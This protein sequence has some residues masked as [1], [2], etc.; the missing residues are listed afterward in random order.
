MK[1]LFLSI[2]TISTVLVSCKNKE[3]NN[4][5]IVEIN[6]EK[7]VQLKSPSFDLLW[8]TDTIFKTPESCFF[9]EKCNV[10]YVSNIN[11]APRT[12]DNNGF[13]STLSTDGKLIKKEWVT[14]LS[15]PKGMDVFNEILYVSDIDAIVEIDVHTGKILKRTELAGALM[16]NDISI[17][18]ETGVVYVS[19]M[20]TG[21]IYSFKNGK[22]T[23]WKDN[24]NKPNGVLVDGDC[25]LI[26]S[27]EDN[28]LK[29]FDINTKEEK[30]L[31]ASNIG[32]ADGIVKLHSGNYVTSDWRGEVFRIK[33]NKPTS[34]FNS[35]EN[36]KAQTA[37]I[38]SIPDKNIILVPTFFGNSVKAFQLKE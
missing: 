17:N 7:T 22:F 24:F 5:P 26:A 3:T 11:N 6:T 15:A 16:L 37:D 25:L 21:K 19:A 2:I 35:I 28:T 30:E 20:D 12:K 13:I 36:K 33:D 31:I 27:V 34:L 8:A 14:G 38:G 10:I 1:N 4:K 32:R 23:L 29:A 18:K 9:D